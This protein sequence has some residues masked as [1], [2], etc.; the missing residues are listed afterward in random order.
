MIVTIGEN[1]AG[2]IIGKLAACYSGLVL[3]VSEQV[4]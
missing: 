2:T 4:K 3:V 1:A